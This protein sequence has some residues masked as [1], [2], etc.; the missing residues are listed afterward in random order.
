MDTRQLK[1]FMAV[2]GTR[3]FTKAAEMLDYAQSSITGQVGSLEDELGTKLFQ[4]LGRQVMLTREGER[5]IEYAEKILQLFSEAKEAVSESLN[6]R[7]T[8]IIGAP[9]TLSAVRLPPLIQQFH[10][11]YPDV[12]I[13]LKKFRAKEM[14]TFLRNSQIDVAF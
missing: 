10:S 8:L 14:I 9:E 13:V 5:F 12:E 2:A 6:P 11:R 1:A 4:R 7:G 3:S